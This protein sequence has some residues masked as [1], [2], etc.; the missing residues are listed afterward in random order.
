MN[1]LVI[2]ALT[3]RVDNSTD[4][5]GK[6]TNQE[7]TAVAS[8]DCSRQSHIMGK[9]ASLVCLRSASDRN[10][11]VDQFGLYIGPDRCS[12]LVQLGQIKVP[13]GKRLEP[14]SEELF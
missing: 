7:L 12:E 14:M 13:L 5:S 11:A 2:N 1:Q 4:L 10:R 8:T 3:G 9:E 6:L